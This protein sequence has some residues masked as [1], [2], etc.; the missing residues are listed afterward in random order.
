MVVHVGAARIENL[1]RPRPDRL[2]HPPLK[3]RRA[4]VRLYV[5]HLARRPHLAAE[6]LTAGGIVRKTRLDLLLCC[7]FAVKVHLPD[8]SAHVLEPIVIA[9]TF[10]QIWICTPET[11]RTV[12]EVVKFRRNL[13]APKLSVDM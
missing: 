1:D 10:L 2:R 12:G 8:E 7:K 9:R 5:R 3:V 11:M 13:H 4:L 6:M